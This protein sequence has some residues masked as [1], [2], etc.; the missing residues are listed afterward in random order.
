MHPYKRLPLTAVWSRA[1]A[2]DFDAGAL[3]QSRTPL[4]RHGERV[5]SA[6]S[7]FASNIVPH[8][9]REGFTYLRAETP[10]PALPGIPA[11]HLGYDTFSAAYGHVYTV[12]Q[13]WQL[14]QRSHG[15]FTPVEDRWR[16]A[17]GVIDPFRPGLRYHAVTD[18]E[19]DLLTAQHLRAVR[20][21]FSDAD[22][23]IFTLGLT[24]GWVSRA[25]GAVFPVCPGTV[26]GTFDPE[27]HAFV[28]FTAAEMTADL[29]A[30]IGGLR[31]VNPS[32]RILLTVSPVPLVATA[33]DSHVLCA[34][35]YSKSALRVVAEDAA[36]KHRRVTYF[37]AYEIVTGPQAPDR[38]FATDRRHVTQE[39]VDVV[40][41][42][43]LKKCQGRQRADG[44]V[45]GPVAT[46][47]LVDASVQPLSHAIVQAECEEER[48]DPASALQ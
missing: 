22:V 17:A 40:M 3:V 5:A 23:F 35:T 41:T 11:E 28:N 4:V 43:F 7:C 2:R 15:E 34:S 20:K 33:T 24:E 27:R 38:Y 42:A 39:A 13:L 10:H 25:D 12:R 18:R 8:L 37:P 48:L 1:V 26:A 31:V 32:V 21:V 30:F 19:F 6:G 46:P 47:A 29:D 36:R 44:G 16:T 45:A 14:F 9:E